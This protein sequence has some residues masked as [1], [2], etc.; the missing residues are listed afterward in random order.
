[1]TSSPLSPPHIVAVSGSLHAPST[2]RIVI[3]AIGDAIARHRDVRTDVI[4]LHEIAG[5]VAAAVVGGEMSPVLRHALRILD[6][7]DLVIAATPVY[8]GSYTGLLKEFIDLVPQ[9][10]LSG[11]PVL[12]AASGGSDQHSLIIDHELRPLFAFFGAHT[13][14][15]GIYTRP[16]DFTGHSAGEDLRAQI[17]RSVAAALAF[18]P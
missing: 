1:M 3:D 2:T 13:L 6:G 17:E 9:Q 16:G 4:E 18:L 14:P 10:S 5:D 7:A 15:L 12:L 11:V 8:R